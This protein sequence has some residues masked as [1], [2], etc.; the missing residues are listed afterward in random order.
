MDTQRTLAYTF[1]DTES[2]WDR[3]LFTANRMIHS[4]YQHNRIGS[5]IINAAALF[6]VDIACDGT[7]S[8]GSVKSW[9]QCTHKTD[10]A[11][12]K[13]LFDNLAERSD[14]V[15]VTWGGVPAD[16]QILT[17]TAMEF[18]L[19]LPSQFQERT[20]ATRHRMHLDLS[21]AMKSGGKTWHHLSEVAHRIGVPLAL[22]RDKARFFPTRSPAEWRLLT[23]H[24]ELDTLITAIVMV[25]W[26][27]AQGAPGLR[28]E[29]AIIGM[30]AAFLRQRPAHPLAAELKAFSAELEQWIAEDR[31]AA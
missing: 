6:D 17:L 4:R 15:V 26:R 12:T 7:V 31:K 30:I 2:S 28:F 8:F 10:L 9:S 21:L 13:A 3:D 20:A 11:V 27:I 14:R 19:V 23:G 24:C 18:G 1:V 16:Q 25:A 22:L 29:P 5:R